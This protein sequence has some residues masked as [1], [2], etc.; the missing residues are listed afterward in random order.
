MDKLIV[1]AAVTGSLITRD[2]NPNL[3]EERGGQL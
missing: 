3:P 2:Q 1:T